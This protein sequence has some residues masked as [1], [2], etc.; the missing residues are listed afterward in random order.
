M[1][2][3]T[4]ILDWTSLIPAAAMLGILH[5]KPTCCHGNRSSC[6]STS[7]KSDRWF[8]LHGLRTLEGSPFFPSLIK[9]HF[10]CQWLRWGLI[11]ARA[12]LGSQ[13]TRRY[14]QATLAVLAPVPRVTL[15]YWETMWHRIRWYYSTNYRLMKRQPLVNVYYPERISIYYTTIYLCSL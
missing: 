3:S 8:L 14:T 4:Q 6:Q 11:K 12:R 9:S 2:L 15:S 7:C 5:T 10:Q 13:S 1:F